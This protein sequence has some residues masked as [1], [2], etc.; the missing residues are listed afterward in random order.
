MNESINKLLTLLSDDTK[1]LR[2]Y[3]S[4]NDNKESQDYIRELNIKELLEFKKTVDKT[5]TNPYISTM[6]LIYDII[7]KNIN[8]HVLS[9]YKGLCLYLNEKEFTIEEQ[10]EVFKYLLQTTQSIKDV[11]DHVDIIA[12]LNNTIFND[13]TTDKD[14]DRAVKYLEL[15][16]FD[17]ETINKLTEY[18]KKRLIKYNKLSLSDSLSVNIPFKSNNILDQMNSIFDLDTNLIYLNDISYDDI[19]HVTAQLIK[20]GVSDN[21]I[22]SFIK[23]AYNKYQITDIVSEYKKYIRNKIIYYYPDMVVYF[24]YYVTEIS[25]NKNDKKAWSDLMLGEYEELPKDGSYQFEIEEAKKLIK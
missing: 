17:K 5:K 14:I 1:Y 13:N 23:N 19:I 6:L 20:M 25:N 3:L 2:M 10:Y 15:L 8:N 24:D 16:N 18:A 11:E 22:I 7:S 12:E 21:N 4:I 9:D